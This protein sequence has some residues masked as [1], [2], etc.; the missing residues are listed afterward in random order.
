[1]NPS[2]SQKSHDAI[3]S[4]LGGSAHLVFV[5]GGLHHRLISAT[6]PASVIDAVPQI[7]A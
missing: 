5:T 2:P 6:P 3:P 4:P 7:P 1:L